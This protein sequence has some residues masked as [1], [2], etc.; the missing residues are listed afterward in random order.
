MSVARGSR[1]GRVLGVDLGRRRIGVAVSDSGRMLAT[2]LATID[3]AGGAGSDERSLA[4]LVELV[5]EVA[6]TV[7][8]VGLPLALGGRPTGA[9]HQALATMDQLRQ[10]LG[11]RDV[12]VVAFDERLTTVTAERALGEAGRRGQD[13]RR[14]VDQ[15][16]ATVLLQ[17]WLDG[18]GRRQRPSEA[19]LGSEAPLQVQD[20]LRS[21]AGSGSG[22]R[23]RRDRS[24]RSRHGGW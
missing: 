3:V 14:V 21:Q 13:R 12:Q 22:G 5:D 10:M 8:V 9:A 6:A 7:V 15:A 23:A 19:S 24:S 1:P 16:A 4:E 17:A 20:P 11:H 2:P 18:H